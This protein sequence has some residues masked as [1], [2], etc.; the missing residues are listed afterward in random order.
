MSE[1]LQPDRLLRDLACSI[2]MLLKYAKISLDDV[3]AAFKEAYESVHQPDAEQAPL[4]DELPVMQ[5]QYLTTLITAWRGSP[6]FTDD[7]G[8]PLELPLH[9]NHPSIESL[10]ARLSASGRLPDSDISIENV[11]KRFIKHRTT[12]LTDDRRHRLIDLVFRIKLASGAAALMYI[13]YV[14][15]LASTCAHNIYKGQGGRSQFVSHTTRFPV[16]RIPLLCRMLEEEG[17]NFLVRMDEHTAEYQLAKSD[18]SEKTSCVGIGI[19]LT[20]E[21]E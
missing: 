19:Y 2:T 20:E 17:M 5:V 3:N 11:G 1:N 8:Q 14:L 18:Q 12:E 4:E 6:E 13:N 16:S 9:G 21:P 7:R 15:G 10:I